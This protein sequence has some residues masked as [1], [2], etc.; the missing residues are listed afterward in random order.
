MAK[1]YD[2]AI[3][4]AGAGGLATAASLLRRKRDLSVCVVDPAEMHYYQPGWTLVGAGVF[5]QQATVRRTES[6]IPRGVDW[7]KQA[8]TGFAPD[9]N[10]VTL[11][12][13]SEISYKILVVAAGLKLDW[14]AIKGLEAAL[15]HDGVTSNYSYQTAPYTWK[16]VQEIRRGRALFTQPA[17]PIKCAGAPQ[18]ALYL[19]CDAW[20]RAGVLRNIEVEFML[21][22]PA[23]FGV[24]YYV[25]SLMQYIEKYGVKLNFLANLTEIDGAARK[26]VFVQKT[27]DGTETAIE[28]NY[29]F[30]HVCPPQTAPDVVKQSSLANAAGWLDV[31][32]ATLQHKRYANVFGVGDVAGT[33][34]AKTAAAVRK[35]APVAA[36]NIL[37]Q[38]SGG[39]PR[40][41]Y[42]G[43]GSCPLTVERGKIVLA[44]FGYGGKILPTFPVDG[45]VPRRLA[46]WLKTL[47]MPELY[48]NWMLKGREPL[49]RPHNPVAA[50]S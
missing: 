39:G 27:S 9:A 43:Y 12:D 33:S 22:T 7:I 19:S 37:G 44:E 10:R 24:A 49:A 25:P 4:G 46:W 18:K 16:L 41:A 26:A 15:G 48:W 23:L 3:I 31:D 28:R 32:E 13:G 35:Q 30:I 45:R 36:E 21:N 20:A 34:N 50:K 38:L 14:A 6:L 47:V 42:D 8:A 29:D 40:F 5:S 1:S 11:A 2:V 17:M